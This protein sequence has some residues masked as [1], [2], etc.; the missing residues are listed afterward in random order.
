MTPNRKYEKGR[1]KE[2]QTRDWLRDMGHVV[3]RSAGSK[4]PF[5]IVAVSASGVLLVQVKAGTRPTKAEVK[6]LEAIEIPLAWC[7]KQIWYWPDYARE[8][9]VQVVD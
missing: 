5:D 7:T 6:K 4:G 2:N 9:E 1:R 8:P 3:M